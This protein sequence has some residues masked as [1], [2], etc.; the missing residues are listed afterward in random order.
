MAKQ[1]I[2][3]YMF[4][5][6]ILKCKENDIKMNSSLD[7][8]E[9]PVPWY[10]I[11]HPK[12]NVIIDGGIAVECAKDPVGYW[13]AITQV[14]WPVMKEEEGCVNALKSIGIS[15]ESIRYVL[16]SHLHLDHTGALGHFPNATH[17]VQRSEYDYAYTAD[18]FSA[19]GYIK[20]D[21]D[22]PNLKWYFL[23]GESHDEFDVFGD[24]TIRIIFTPGHSPGHSSFLVTLPESGSLLLTVDASYTLDHWNEKA[25]P[26]FMTSAVDTV[27]SVTKLH[28]MA[29]RY[30]A[31]VVT[32][33]DPDAWPSFKKAPDFY[34]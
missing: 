19:A 1:S 29:E 23:K 18:W 8:Y 30:N 12:G 13:G 16:Q 10:F 32:G 26:G 34:A 25:L 17:I 3:L 21:F 24:G 9:I 2:R 4:Q 31:Q 6:G 11:M 15:P 20:K 14:S 22:K 28:Y 5:T 33:H 7:P 27:R